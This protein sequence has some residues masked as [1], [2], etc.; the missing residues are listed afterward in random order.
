MQ[1]WCE[2]DSR[3]RLDLSCLCTDV[4]HYIHKISDDWVRV[5]RVQ[6][7]LRFFVMSD[8]SQRYRQRVLSIS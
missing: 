4:G 6:P 2:V 7:F 3:L 1:V 8:S 5:D